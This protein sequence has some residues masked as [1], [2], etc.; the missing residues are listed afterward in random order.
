MDLT[1]DEKDLKK[2]INGA[3]AKGELNKVPLDVILD[4]KTK[5]QFKELVPEKDFNRWIN[6]KSQGEKDAYIA[7]REREIKNSMAYDAKTSKENDQQIIKDSKFQDFQ[8]EAALLSGGQQK[9]NWL[10]KIK[11][12]KRDE[13]G[14]AKLDNNGKIQFEYE[15]KDD[16][17]KELDTELAQR[18]MGKTTNEDLLDL[19]TEFLEKHGS[20]LSPNQCKF[21]GN[22]ARPEK[23]SAVESSLNKSIEE[24]EEAKEEQADLGKIKQ[25]NE[26][27]K[28]LKYA[29]RF[30]E[31]A[32]RPTRKKKETES[33]TQQ[34][35][36]EKNTETKQSEARKGIEELKEM[37]ARAK[38]KAALI[39]VEIA[40]IRLEKTKKE[41]GSKEP[42]I[43]KEGGSGEPE[44]E[45]EGGSGEPLGFK[46]QEPE[47]N[48]GAKETEET[49]E[50]PIGQQESENDGETT[51][52]SNENQEDKKTKK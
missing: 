18:V 43:E 40:R 3:L 38:A 24:A 45:K 52:E 44:I 33:G 11:G 29:Y 26:S 30:D 21:F 36:Q 25:Y 28:A 5:E 27:L 1:V 7:E 8:E 9:D 15:V 37:E 49:P 6:G 19:K 20:L 39:D 42:E 4:P 48:N 14:K 17:T 51:A 23:I 12:I 47:S 46:T 50:E 31:N 16:N 35:K 34:N 41:G 32:E 13:G 22:R 2:E 10:Y